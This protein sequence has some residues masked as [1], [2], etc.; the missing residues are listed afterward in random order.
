MLV[1]IAKAM[2]KFTGPGLKMPSGQQQAVM[3]LLNE[4]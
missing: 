3:L 4:K 1:L 2:I